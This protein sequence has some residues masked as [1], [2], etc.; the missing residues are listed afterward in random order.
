MNQSIEFH[1][2]TTQRGSPA[3]QI[4]TDLYRVQKKNINGSIRY[5]C[6]NERC[7]ASLTI[8]E[9]K[10]QIMRGT[11]KHG[12]RLL[13]FHIGEIVN[14]FRQAIVSDIRTPLPQIYDKFAKKFLRE[15]GSAAEMLMFRQVRATGYRVRTKALPPCP[16]KQDIATFH[17]PDVFRLNL[18]HEPF[19]I[20]DS[21]NPYRIIVF[22]SKSSLNHLASCSAIHSDRT[23]F[24]APRY[25]KQAYIIHGWRANR[26][27]ASEVREKNVEKM[28]ADL[29]ALPMVPKH[30]VR[31][32][33]D[34]ISQQLRSINPLFNSFLMYFRRTHFTTKP[35]IW[36][37][38]MLIKDFDET[39]TIAIE[40]EEH[41]Q[42]Q[43]RLRHRKNIQR[44]Q[45]LFELKQKL[46]KQHI[47]IEGYCILLRHFSYTY[48]KQ[49]DA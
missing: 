2:T 40:Q 13:P 16:K 35:N 30:V 6:T 33:F 14:E 41:Q 28:I 3:I 45:D 32:R 48:M 19:L 17:I 27:L 36:L 7:N 22:A 46:E 1:Y 23:F 4:G 49:L 10:I 20:H 31:Q 43:T 24:M 47:D 21:A 42:R 8:F 44:D 25:F 18:S 37:W 34:L 26:D 38:I 11:H 15:Y 9:N 39:T 29:I 5:T 12:Q